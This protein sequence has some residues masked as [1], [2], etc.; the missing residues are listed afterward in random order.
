MTG[1]VALVGDGGRRR[2]VR[3]GRRRALGQQFQR[4]ADGL[5]RR[6]ERLRPVGVVSGEGDLGQGVPAARPLH[7]RVGRRGGPRLREG[8][9]EGFRVLAGAVQV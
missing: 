7:D 2:E 4:G 9:V 8:A 5:G 1:L 6:R 3:P